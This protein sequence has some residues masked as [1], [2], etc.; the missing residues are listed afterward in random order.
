RTA[1]PSVHPDIA[2]GLFL[3]RGR[4]GQAARGRAAGPGGHGLSTRRLTP[5]TTAGK[6]SAPPCRPTS[7]TRTDEA[8]RPKDEREGPGSTRPA[9]FPVVVESTIPGWATGENWA[10]TGARNPDNG[11]KQE[12]ASKQTTRRG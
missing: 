7:T 1:G 2:S 5:L 11:E 10:R 12:S 8:F 9:P 3:A 6:R 4:F